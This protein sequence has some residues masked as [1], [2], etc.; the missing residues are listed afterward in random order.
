[1]TT[2]SIEAA[3]AKLDQAL[4]SAEEAK[5][6]LAQLKAQSRPT[7]L[8]ISGID[9]TLQPGERYAG[10]VLDAD[11]KVKHHLVLLPNSPD[12]DV[13]WANATKWAQS[14]GGA[15]PD[16][17]E[18]A[19]LYANCKPHLRPVWHWSCETHANDASYAWSCYFYSGGQDGTHKSAE[20]AA[21]AVRRL[22][23]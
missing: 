10:P 6:L 23:A 19:L 20:V 12:G 15:L 8:K 7:V 21:V 11:G 9:I 18:Q 1:M 3:Q 22:N 13:N 16:R 14:I 5:T 4:A 2:I 17:Q